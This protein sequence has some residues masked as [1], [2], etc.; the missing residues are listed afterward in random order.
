MVLKK[1]SA[2]ET[3]YTERYTAENTLKHTWKRRRDRGE[4][5]TRV[6]FAWSNWWIRR[7][8]LPRK[9]ERD[10]ERTCPPT[11]YGSAYDTCRYSPPRSSATENR[12]PCHP[13]PPHCLGNANLFFSARLGFKCHPLS[14][15]SLCSSYS[16]LFLFRS[17]RLRLPYAVGYPFRLYRFLPPPP[18]T[19]RGLC[20]SHGPTPPPSQPFLRGVARLFLSLRLI[21]YIVARPWATVSGNGNGNEVISET[22]DRRAKNQ[23]TRGTIC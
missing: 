20:S 23:R 22:N 10:I 14:Y 2:K 9:N 21:R 12:T 4:P 18:Y 11:L 1:K 15:T 19:V 6:S 16:T 8:E 13:W 3:R 17:F 5:V 7:V